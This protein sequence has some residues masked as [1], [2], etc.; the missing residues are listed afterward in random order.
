ME[1]TVTE[2]RNNILV[3]QALEKISKDNDPKKRIRYFR[4]HIDTLL[5][6]K[7]LSKEDAEQLYARLDELEATLDKPN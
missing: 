6:R 2:R 5:Y 7:E 1:R 4:I 3:G